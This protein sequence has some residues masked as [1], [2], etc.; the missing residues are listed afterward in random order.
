M[1]GGARLSSGRPSERTLCGKVNAEA[2]DRGAHLESSRKIMYA[3][4]Q[5]RLRYLAPA[6]VA[7]EYVQKVHDAMALISRKGGVYDEPAQF[8]QLAE[9][10]VDGAI[11]CSISKPDLE[12]FQ[13]SFAN[14]PAVVCS[15]R[16]MI[17]G[18]THV[19]FNHRRGG[20]L[21]TR[22][23]LEMGHRRIALLVGIFGSAFSSAQDLQPYLDQPLLAGPYAGI[24]ST[25]GPGRPWTSSTWSLAPSCWASLI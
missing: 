19:Y 12:A 21:A 23:L 18:R 9:A 11:Y 4:I 10:G 3:T 16:D 17:E 7:P 8:R 22:H 20:Y 25:S 1:A 2:E 13:H 15:C 5:N 14:T 6:N 24:D